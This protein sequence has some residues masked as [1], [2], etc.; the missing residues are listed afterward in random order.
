MVEITPAAQKA[1][2]EYLGET[3]EKV[4]RIQFA[5]IGC[6]GPELKLSLE[7]PPEGA[8]IE[9]VE[10]LK[11]VVDD[12]VLVFSDKQIIDYVKNDEME[13]FSLTSSGGL[14]CGG[15]CSSCGH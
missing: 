2:S 1:L 7:V 6:S 15:D 12:D 13:G 5:G 14:S 9:E 3:S 4:V 8:L 10:G 11:V